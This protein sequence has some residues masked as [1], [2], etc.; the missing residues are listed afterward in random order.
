MLLIILMGYSHQIVLYNS[1]HYCHRQVSLW[2]TKQVCSQP[3]AAGIQI[4]SCTSWMVFVND[5]FAAW[6]TSNSIHRT[7][8]VKLLLYNFLAGASVFISFSF[9]YEFVVPCHL[10]KWSELCIAFSFCFTDSSF[11][12]DILNQ[13]SWLALFIAFSFHCLLHSHF[14]N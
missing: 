1:L 13:N 12:T 7:S 3:H 9:Y 14:S 8:F 11:L 10:D 4:H 5:R 2:C 6:N